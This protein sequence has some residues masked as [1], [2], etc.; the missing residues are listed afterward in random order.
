LPLSE[1][2]DR[3]LFL[4]GRGAGGGGAIAR[5]PSLV[6]SGAPLL[7][8]LCASRAPFLSSFRSPGSPFLTPLR[9][10]LRAIRW[11]RRGRGWRGGL[12]FRL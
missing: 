5:V 3:L 4:L 8:P 11:R 7:T 2:D 9:A 10:R 6:A 12:G 1:P